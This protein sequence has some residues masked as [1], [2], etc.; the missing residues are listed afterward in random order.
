VEQPERP[1]RRGKGKKKGKGQGRKRNPCLKKY[2]NFC[3]HGTCQYY[4]DL[5]AASCV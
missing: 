2:K 3:I 1:Q 4:K 5:R